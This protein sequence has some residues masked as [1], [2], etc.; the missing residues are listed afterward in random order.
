M[1]NNRNPGE[2]PNRRPVPTPLTIPTLNI[3]VVTKSVRSPN[4]NLMPHPPRSPVISQPL[5][6]PRSPVI[7][8]PVTNTNVQ[9]VRGQAPGTLIQAMPGVTQAPATGVSVGPIQVPNSAPNLTSITASGAGNPN[10]PVNTQGYQQV[11]PIQLLAI[12]QTQSSSGGPNQQRFQLI[13]TQHSQQVFKNQIPPGAVLLQNPPGQQL[14]APTSTST[15]QPLK[16]PNVPQPMHTMTSSVSSSAAFSSPVVTVTTAQNMP[17]IAPTMSAPPKMMPSGPCLNIP[18]VRL[19]HPAQQQNTPLTVST[20]AAASHPLPMTVGPIPVLKPVSPNRP[21]LTPVSQ[22]PPQLSPHTPSHPAPKPR[23][24]PDVKP[25]TSTDMPMNLKT[26]PK[27]ESGDQKSIFPDVGLQEIEKKIKQEAMDVDDPQQDLS[28]SIEEEIEIPVEYNSPDFVWEEYLE[29]TGATAAPPTSFKHVENS[30]Q[31]G[32]LKGMKLEVA[33]KSNVD[34]YWVASVIMTCGPLLRLRYDGYGEDNVAD[35]WCDV[36]NADMHPIGWCA[37]NGKRLQPP[38]AIKYKY[39]N[40]KEFLVKTLTGARTAPSYLLDKKTGTTPVDQIKQ[41]M[42]LEIQHQLYRQAVWIVK[43]LENVGGRLLMRYE[44]TN[45]AVHDFWLFYL[46]SRVHPVGWAH[47]NDCIY[48]PPE[49]IKREHTN[50]SEWSE[51]LQCAIKDYDDFKPP[52]DIFKDQEEIPEHKFK[53]GWKL[54]VL[55]PENQTQFCAGTVIDVINDYYFIVEIDDLREGDERRSVKVCC[56]A[57]SPNIFPIQWCSW[58]GIRLTVPGGWNKPDF[59]WADYCEHCKAEPAPEEIFTAETPDHEFKRGMKLEAINPTHPYQI[60]AA[61]ITKI[62]DRLMWVHLDNSTKL[63]ANHIVDVESHDIYPVGWCE[64]NSY[65]LKPPRRSGFTKGLKKRVAVVQ[66]ERP[67]GDT[68]EEFRTAAFSMMRNG[69][70]PGVGSLCP[71]IYYN[72]R[73]FSGPFLSKGRIAELPK[74]VGPGPV[75]LVLKEVLSM[76]INVAYKSSRVLRELQLEG[77]PNPN[78]HQQILKA[79]YKGKSYR[80]TVELCKSADQIEEFCRQVCIKLECCPNLFSPHFVDSQ[81]PENC[82]QLTKTKYT[83]FYGKKKKRKIGRPPG[84]HSNIVEPG[85]KKTGKCRRKRRINILLQ[86]KQSD[87][88]ENFDGKDDD[89]RSTESKDM[90]NS[91]ASRDDEPS[92]KKRRYMR[93]VATPTGIQTRGAKLPK[94][95]FERKTHKKIMLSKNDIPPPKPVSM[96]TP[97]KHVKPEDRLCLDSNPLE[98]SV[99]D[100]VM[101]IKDT[102]CA[103]LARLFREHEIDG[104]ALLLLTLPTVQEHMELKLGPAIK[105]CHHIER[106]KIAFYEQFAK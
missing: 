8:Q 97:F 98:W 18:K 30:L 27:L 25:S 75:I 70:T 78:M 64:S 12:P 65:P 42:R 33:N 2:G 73:C 45:T 20:P 49:V 56:H 17:Q 100:V 52:T 99:D 60:C 88:D 35:F 90:N 13:S 72:H 16:I 95:T 3:P 38:E 36:L 5:Q 7:S 67:F 61:T 34:T 69:E 74:C 71:K 66:P 82:S 62:I 81:C 102:D 6:V 94:F 83:Q 50:Y 104:Q 92:R 103:S 39:D 59:D 86:E 47:E 55:N 87:S 23:P 101:F 44:G 32:F 53:K 68:P 11:M 15:F 85:P 46:H 29:E 54:E 106:V 9:G 80:A 51:I 26:V 79:K 28:T 21:Q 91:G 96:Q 37:A 58:K 31:S 76:L 22:N 10:I 84:G 19:H 105:L 48:R 4:M 77:D 41:G 24:E 89:Q 43:V 93:H 1:A 40:W 63:V 57:N 14:L